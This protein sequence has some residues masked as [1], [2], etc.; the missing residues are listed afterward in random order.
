M[1]ILSMT[2]TFGKLS[3]STLQLEPGMNIIHAPNEWGKSTWCAFIEAMLYGIDTGSRSKTGFLADKEH[4]APWSGEP[5]SGKMDILWEGKKITIERK[6]KG[7]TPFGEIKVYETESGLALPELSVN[8]CGE[9]LLGVERSVFARAGFLKQSQM[10]V[11]ED[12]KLRRRLNQLVTTGD[13]SGESE[14]LAGKLRDLKNRCRFNKKGL[15]PELEAQQAAVEQKLAGLTQLQG[16]IRAIEAAQARLKEENRLLENHLAALSYQ[17]HLAYAQKLAAAQVAKEAADLQW[18]AASEGCTKLPSPQQLQE[19]L[20][21]LRKLRDQREALTL[22]IVSPLP[23]MPYFSSVFQGKDPQA[24][25]GEAKTD[26]EIVR[27]LKKNQSKPA[28]YIFAGL[29]LLLGVA[30]LLLYPQLLRKAVGGAFA[31]CGLVLLIVQLVRRQK[32]SQ[33]IA[34]IMQKYPGLSPERWLPEAESYAA[35]QRAYSQNL[36]QQQNALADFNRR[37]EENAAAFAALTGNMSVAEFEQFCLDAQNQYRLLQAAEEKC[38]QAETVLQALSATQKE[39]F[40]P[41]FPDEMTLSASETQKRL[42]ENRAEEQS[43]RHRLGLYQGQMEALGQEQALQAQK[44]AMA[45]RHERLETH[46]RALQLAMETLENASRELQRRYAPRISQRA[47]ELFSQLTGGRYKRLALCQDLSLE[48]A[49]QDENT[50]RGSLWR[51]DGTVDQLYLALRL[52]VAQELTPDAPL[53]LDD[54]LV[55]FDDTRLASAMEILKK[56]SQHKQVIIFTCQSRE[57]GVSL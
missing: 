43:L 31:L 12:E 5:M 50:L 2:A 4:Y 23:E 57:K 53:I 39:V 37:K 6:N 35:A 21:A 28:P 14:Q 8:H 42:A 54:A 19:D 13:E 7:R 32:L 45:A 48:T 16:Q 20:S 10:P 15:L 49:A 26:T 47:Q 30:G 29:L 18:Q 1:K 55:R 36:A 22:E 51:S 11:T 17:E 24:A 27:E 41:T 44:A 38:R 52:A 3:A 46:Y 40:A 56:E 34:A 33:R 9:L 25:V